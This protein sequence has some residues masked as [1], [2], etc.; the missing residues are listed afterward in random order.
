MSEKILTEAELREAIAKIRVGRW[1]DLING[2]ADE[3]MELIKANC[4]L[5]G[6]QAESVPLFKDILSVKIGLEVLPEAR[7]K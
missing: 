6:Q 3:I 2:D 4:W 5:K 7:E 1:L